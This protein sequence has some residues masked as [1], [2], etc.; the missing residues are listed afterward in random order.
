MNN[1]SKTHADNHSHFKPHGISVATVALDL[2]PEHIA[3]VSN[4]VWT[5]IDP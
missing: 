4:S 3:N 5:Q 1:L 2:Q